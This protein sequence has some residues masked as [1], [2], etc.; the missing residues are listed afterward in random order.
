MAE[1]WQDGG[2]R[3]PDFADL[4]EVCGW[5]PLNSARLRNQGQLTLV[6]HELVPC[7]L[8]AITDQALPVRILTGTPGVAHRFEGAFHLHECR[9]NSWIQLRGDDARLRLDAGAIDSAWIFQHAGTPQPSRQLRLYDE[10][11]RA[12]ALIDDVPGF[13]GTENPIW[14][15]LVNA[16]SD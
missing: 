5:F 6:D 10:S 15:T 12:L 1:R 4:A 13:G 14:R 11:G 2:H 16:L 9:R 8:E 3:D 7:F